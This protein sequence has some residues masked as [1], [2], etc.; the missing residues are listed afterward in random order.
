MYAWY[1][2][3]PT[4][5]Q[6]GW[7][8]IKRCLEC[9]RDMPEHA[10]QQHK[11]A[12]CSQMD[13]HFCPGCRQRLRGYYWDMPEVQFQQLCK[14]RKKRT[15]ACKHRSAE[16][17]PSAYTKLCRFCSHIIHQEVNR[18][19]A[20]QRMSAKRAA[21]VREHQPPSLRRSALRALLQH[22]ERLMSFMMMGAAAPTLGTTFWREMMEES[23][24]YYRT[25]TPEAHDQIRRNLQQSEMMIPLPQLLVAFDSKEKLEA[26][27]PL[28]EAHAH[29]DC[30]R[31]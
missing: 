27:W 2:T 5:P 13:S 28:L 8:P 7:C 29:R 3:V 16:L 23:K 26:L 20:V 4:K 24:L 12:V 15:L 1:R 17:D 22:P 9:E 31:G 18:R 11:G 30:G 14:Q 6:F 10:K 21:T 19:R 25:V